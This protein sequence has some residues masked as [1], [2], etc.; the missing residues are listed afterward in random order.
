MQPPHSL[1]WS[2]LDQP[3]TPRG[4]LGEHLDVD[5]AIV[6]GGFTG[7]WTARELK[8]RDPS[9]QIAVLEKSVCG[10]GASGRNGG[11]ASALYPVSDESVV[12]RHGL[13][14]FTHLRHELEGAVR[15]LGASMR[16]DSIDAHFV[17]GGTLTFAR[18]EVQAARL[19]QHVKSSHDLGYGEDDLRWLEREEALELADVQGA[20]GATYSPHCARIHP[21]RL[22]RGLAEVDERLGVKIFEN[23]TVTRITKA[24]GTHPSEVV[25]A[26]GTVH[27]RFVVRATEGFTP[28]LPKER[29]S[30]API[31]SL[32]I[33]TEPQSTRFWE[34]VGLSSYETFA[35][36]RHLIIY[37]QRTDDGRIAFGGRG[38]PYHFA[39]TVE[40]RF[41]ENPKV[42]SL[43][44]STLRELFPSLEGDVT[45]RWGGP[46]ALPRDHSPSVIVDY[47][48]GLASAG[49]YT[50][51]GV[52][53][54]YVAANALADLIVAPGIET[55]RTRLPFVQH[56][57]K[58]W[59]IEPFRW[60]GINLGLGLAGWA[61]RVERRQGR[62]SRAGRLLDRLLG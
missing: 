15:S 30:V 47:Q 6:G 46:L 43:L 53:L 2:T 55:S 21:A 58:R 42:F 39:S 40:E 52:V 62:E 33:A 34:E 26:T 54:S 5:V 25:T 12:A 22:V 17:Q 29:R 14:T 10:F 57:P 4:A 16:A 27:A 44:E 36:D 24:R 51:D 13:E 35:D 3:I 38:A 11:W 28:T 50:G 23:T 20:L 37:G 18:S 19:Q 59:E 45:H 61:D 60:A 7:L 48:S 1:W 56:R 41:D 32:M 8:R 9:L 31:Y 49:S